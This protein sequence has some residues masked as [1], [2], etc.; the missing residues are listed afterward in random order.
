MGGWGARYKRTHYNSQDEVDRPIQLAEHR[1]T[2]PPRQADVRAPEGV[3]ARPPVLLQLQRR[4]A[5]Y[6]RDEGS[7]DAQREYH[8]EVVAGPG[9]EAVGDPEPPEEEEPYLEDD[10][11]LA[12]G[13]AGDGTVR[14]V[15]RVYVAIVPVV[16][17]LGVPRQKR[18]G[19]DHGDEPLQRVLEPEEDVAIVRV[20]RVPYPVVV[21]R[22]RGAAHDPPD[23][24]D[25]R[26]RLRE[27]EAYLP[28]VGGVRRRPLDP[29]E[30]PHV[31]GSVRDLAVGFGRDG[32]QAGGGGGGRIMRRRRGS[33]E[34]VESR[35]RVVVII[36][37]VVAVVGREHGEG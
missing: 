31:R 33:R 26:H 13:A 35:R 4:R 24:G 16:D 9:V 15:D 8:G 21:P 10:L 20:E 2:A 6:V 22:R 28:D 29:E 3:I 34:G 37:A 18:P 14:L 23:Q 1:L 5:V 12:D 11:T 19:E 27:L 25:P 7:E 17:G 32:V 30:L 36:P